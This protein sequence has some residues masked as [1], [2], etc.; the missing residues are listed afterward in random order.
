[1][2]THNI[3]TYTF[4]MLIALTAASC[5]QD[6][7]EGTTDNAGCDLT[8][9]LSSNTD[10]RTSVAGSD[11]E[12]IKDW[13]IIIQN[14]STKSVEAT[15]KRS[16]IETNTDMISRSSFSLSQH[17]ITL[18]PGVKNIY[19][20]ANFSDAATMTGNIAGKDKSEVENITTSMFSANGYTLSS[21]DHLWMSMD[22]TVTIGDV[23]RQSIDLEL[24]RMCGKLQFSFS[25]SY[26]TNDVVVNSIKL[27]SLTGNG[28]PIYMLPAHNTFDG[29]TP[30]VMPTG[31]TTSEYTY[32]PST[33]LTVTAGKATTTDLS[34]FVNE[35]PSPTLPSTLGITINTKKGSADTEDLYTVSNIKYIERN[36]WIQIPVDFSDY[37]LEPTAIFYPP[38]GGYPQT[39]IT[40]DAN[41]KFYVTFQGA[42][43]FVIN[44]NFK[45]NG[46]LITPTSVTVNVTGTG[47]F[48]T[49]P[50]YSNIDGTLLGSLNGTAGTSE[51]TM[52]YQVNTGTETFTM[53]RK[54]YIIAQ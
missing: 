7:Y 22:K 33:A 45:K 20:F 51:I 31:S 21:T 10:T 24:I 15:I 4:G 36:D 27:T 17:G 28:Q 12:N 3:K 30:P 8:I 53:V 11:D 38:I 9:N 29:T 34:F 14:A 32:T 18:T 49:T 25:N 35:T 50:Y 39:K 5:S 13:Y 54:L 23:Q 48:A 46:V 19:A 42:G 41:Q 6:N 44:P 1:M 47:I 2:T 43:D 40:S 26:G 37:T 52:T 16:D